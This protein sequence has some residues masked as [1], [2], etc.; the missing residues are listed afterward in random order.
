MPPKGKAAAAPVAAEVPDGYIAYEPTKHSL[1]VDAASMAA[2]PFDTTESGTQFFRAL[3]LPRGKSVHVPNAPG[4]Y[5]VM[6]SYQIL[7]APMMVHFE[8]TT[9]KKPELLLYFEDFGM[10]SEKLNGISVVTL[11][12]PFKLSKN[13]YKGKNHRRW[14]PLENVVGFSAVAMNTT[15][16]STDLTPT[17]TAI[18]PYKSLKLTSRSHVTKYIQ[19]PLDRR[20][21]ILAEHCKAEIAAECSDLEKAGDR[22]GAEKAR[23]NF[24]LSLDGML[25]RIRA[26][27]PSAYN[28]PLTARIMV[29]SEG[30]AS[31]ERPEWLASP[32]RQSMEAGSAQLIQTSLR[33]KCEAPP[34]RSPRAPGGS[35]DPLPEEAVEEQEGGAPGSALQRRGSS[36]SSAIVG[37]SDDDLQG[38]ENSAP[39]TEPPAKRV[40]TQTAHYDAAAEEARSKGDRAPP[41]SCLSKA[42]QRR[43]KLTDAALKKSQAELNKSLGLKPDGTP[44]VRNTACGGGYLKRELPPAAAAAAAAAAAK[45]TNLV[46]KNSEQLLRELSD[47]KAT[48]KVR[49]GEISQLK[50]A[51]Q[52]TETAKTAAVDSAKAQL[53]MDYSEKMSEQFQKGAAFASQV[54]TGKPFTF[55]PAT[56]SSSG[57]PG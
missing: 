48:L 52:A 20:V 33:R 46:A 26:W 16:F 8:S 5:L 2:L 10:C 34:P 51:L 30:G 18:E 50:L 11:Q 49:D 55:T 7:L 1:V 15:P 29:F 17:L 47:L 45:A 3:L 31:E 12:P 21:G 56:G 19:Q 57:T 9:Q 38:A 23:N 41:P 53:M 22:S 54:A 25:V 27:P 13:T 14:T 24:Q 43:K 44:Y 37:D 36:R 32:L 35:K 40:R 28:A 6:G 42:E 4:K 39:S